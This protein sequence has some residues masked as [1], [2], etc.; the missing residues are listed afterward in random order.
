MQVRSVQWNKVTRQD[1]PLNEESDPEP[2][3]LRKSGLSTPE[4]K[5]IGCCVQQIINNAH[6]MYLARDEM[7]KSALQ[8]RR[9]RKK[10]HKISTWERPSPSWPCGARGIYVSPQFFP[11]EVSAWTVVPLAVVCIVIHHR[12]QSRCLDSIVKLECVECCACSVSLS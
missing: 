7:C 11:P 4:S 9:K 3:R 8:G 1:E 2:A 10:P 5:C 6:P 12:L